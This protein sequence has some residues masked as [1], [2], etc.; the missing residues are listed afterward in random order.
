[1]RA[2][3]RVCCRAIGASVSTSRSG[4]PQTISTDRSLTLRLEGFAWASLDE[5][6]EREGLS[7]EELITFA[8]LYYLADVDSGR[9]ARRISRSPYPRTSAERADGQSGH[10]FSDPARDPSEAPGRPA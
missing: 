1:V 2:V 8:T 4:E 10:R 7:V 9:V 5:E 3:V 6:A